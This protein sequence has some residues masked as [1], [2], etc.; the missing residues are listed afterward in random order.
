[1]Y[2]LKIEML[3][4]TVHSVLCCRLDVLI[5]AYLGNLRIAAGR[6]FNNIYDI[7]NKRRLETL[8]VLI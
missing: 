5:V 3:V 8:D 4:C 6:E 1:M 2:V 7:H